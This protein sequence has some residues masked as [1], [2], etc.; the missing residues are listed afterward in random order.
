MSPVNAK[1]FFSGFKKSSWAVAG[2]LAAASLSNA[3]TSLIDN[4]DAGTNQNMFLG[5]SYFYADGA[6]GGTTHVLTADSSS[7]NA[8]LVDPAKSFDVG[9]NG[10]PHSLKMSFVYGANKPISASC[11]CPY[12]Q[13]AGFGTQVVAG[14][15]QGAVLNMAG[16]TSITFWA[17]ASAAMLMRFEV[18]TANVTDDG[19]YA[20]SPEPSITTTWTKYTVLFTG[21]LG[22]L[23]RPAWANTATPGVIFD[24][25]KVQKLQFS[26]SAD[27]NTGLDSGTLWL[28]SIQVTG[29]TWVP[30]MAC[31]PC[32]GAQGAGTGAL[33]SDLD[34]PPVNENTAG[35]Y[36]YAYNDAQAHVPPL[37]TGAPQSEFS[38]IITGVDNT[39]PVNPVLTVSPTAGVNGTGAA[40]ISF[41]LGPTFQQDDT[42]TIQPF[43]GIG[44]KTSDALGTVFLNVGTSTGISFDYNTDA[45]STFAYLRLEVKA[46]QVLSTNVGVVHQVLLPATGGVWKSAS[47]PWD[48]LKEPDWAGVVAQPLKTSALE[49]IQWAVQGAPGTT[50]GFA[51]D[52]V[53]IMGVTTIPNINSAILP[54]SGTVRGLLLTQGSDGIHLNYPLPDGVTS[55]GIRLLNL[56]GAVVANRNVAAHG[57]LQTDLN[58]RG[59]QNGIYTLQ[60]RLGN[61][62]KQVVNT[63]FTLLQ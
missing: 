38:E 8:W 52:N 25:T 30:P 41:D 4:F 50:G 54:N 24:S 1:T 48:T 63:N 58:T 42:T 21:G 7:N 37:A 51:I 59:L 9:A 28:D 26:V 56:Q 18:A 23:V 17:K 32:V 36:W 16:A 5:Y 57:T 55:V 15:D 39:D 22:G 53:K 14:T 2:L 46:N 43:V 40:Y 47:I 49:H 19:F 29:Y 44:T 61:S 60:L 62:A 12:G 10:T 20:A 35:G 6:D 33:L 13:F 34:T 3:Q 31:L 11:M 27:D 45:T